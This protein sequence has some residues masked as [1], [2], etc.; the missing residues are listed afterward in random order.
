MSIVL[1]LCV[2]QVDSENGQKKVRI[3]FNYCLVS[4]VLITCDR[5]KLK[6]VSA[7]A[8]MYLSRILHDSWFCFV[9]FLRERAV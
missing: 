6:C 3:R 8:G 1:G 2:I 9:L 7:I 4:H 5:I